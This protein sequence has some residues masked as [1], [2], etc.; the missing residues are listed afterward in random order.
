MS[1]L[2]KTQIALSFAQTMR[3]RL[4]V[5]WIRADSFAKFATD[6]TQ[7]LNEIDPASAGGHSNEDISLVLDKTRRK[8]EE[9]PHEWLLILDNA[10]DLDGFLGRVPSSRGND[11]EMSIARFLPRHGRMLITTRDRRFQGTVAAANDGM[12]V[13]IMTEEESKQLLIGSVPGY[14]IQEGSDTM[15]QAIQLIEE[16]G[17]LPLAIAQAAA[18]ILEQQLTLAEYVSFYEDKK[19]RMGLM[20][21]PAYDFQTTD[22]PN[23]SQSVNITWN[24]SFDVLKEKHP[25]SAIFL[26]YIGCFHWRNIPRTLLQRLPEFRDLSQ[27]VFIQ[28]TKKPLNL[29]LVDEQEPEPGF[30]EYTV[31]PLVHENILSRLTKVETAKYINSLIETIEPVFPFVEDRTDSGWLVAVYLSPHVARIINLCEELNH[32]SQLLSKMLLRMSRFLGVSNLF[33]AAVELAE[34]AKAMGLQ[35]WPSNTEMIITFSENLN[36]Q[37]GDASR[38]QEQQR[39]ARETLE[40]LDSDVVKA[41]MSPS[42]IEM[43]RIALQSDLSSSLIGDGDQA[44][45]E[46]LH[47]KQLA[48]GL[49]NEWNAEGITIRHNLAHA[50]A[51]QRKFE[52]AKELNSTLLGFAETD[53]GKQKVNPRLHLIMLNLRCMILRRTTGG[54][55]IAMYGGFVSSDSSLIPLAN[56][57]L[58]STYI[59]V[60]KESMKQFGIEDSDTWRAANNLT[61]YLEGVFQWAECGSVLQQVF[62]TG[63]EFK[64]RAEGKFTVTLQ[65][66]R[67]R[68]ERYVESFGDTIG[69]EKIQEFGKLLKEWIAISGCTDTA[70]TGGYFDTT[71][72]NRGVLLQQQGLFEDAER[73]HIQ[74]IELCVQANKPIPDVYRYN[75][76]LAIGRQGKITEAMEYRDQH[77]ADLDGSEQAFGSLEAR[78]ERDRTDREIYDQVQAWLDTGQDINKDWEQENKIALRR[79]IFRYGKLEAK[80]IPEVQPRE[81]GDKRGKKFFDFGKKVKISK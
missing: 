63:I 65:E 19:E 61:G 5:F 57:E 21:V 76:M 62:A 47:R 64:V 81:N 39:E 28:L 54:G 44:E 38:L 23:A 66:L 52:E 79:A 74:S 68:A 12:K 72:S 37:Y 67:F 69:A 6:Y 70:S 7:V 15:N 17:Y 29:S 42:T 30:T 25:L 16:L 36:R 78:L 71:V 34:K 24:I 55:E 45:R 43:H 18:N 46:E 22:P 27:Q 8:L 80:R 9:I 53:M 56:E 50:L 73:K 3:H 20:Q 40:W 48:T 14:L 51:K 60:Y 35:V 33:P 75:L 32:S 59:L 4:S 41:D 1:N 11:E 49:V 2:R 31:H 58:H 77:R 10:N 13:E 26:T